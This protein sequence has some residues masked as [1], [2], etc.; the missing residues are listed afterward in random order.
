MLV[1]GLDRWTTWCPSC[2]VLCRFHTCRPVYRGLRRIIAT[3]RNVHPSPVRCGLRSG[4]MPDGHGTAWSLSSRA[5][6]A[7][8]RPVRRCAKIHALLARSPDRD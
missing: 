3:V 1:W 6:L 2:W 4:S 8:L 5:M 7:M